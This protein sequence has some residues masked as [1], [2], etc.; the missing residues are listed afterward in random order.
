MTPTLSIIIINYNT[1][2]LVENCIQSIRQFILSIDYEIIIVDNDSSDRDILHR[3]KAPDLRIIL[4]EENLGFGKA[5]NLGY[6]YSK[7]KFILLLNPDTLLIDNS[8]ELLINIAEYNS[9]AC[10]GGIL[11]DENRQNTHS[12]GKF[13][14][15]KLFIKQYIKS[16]LPF[17]R[18]HQNLQ[19]THITKVDYITGADLL[20]PRSVIEKF[21][22]FNPAFFMYYEETDLQK[23]YN[24]AGI[25]SYI[26]PNVNIIHL[27]GGSFKKK[28]IRRLKM[29]LSGSII[30]AKLNFSLINYIIFR[31]LTLLLNIP[32]ILVYPGNWKEKLSALTLLSSIIKIK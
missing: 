16:Y 24:L 32:K 21:G 6:T 3:L 19:L 9:N 12:F 18:S 26:V 7:G 27:D 8:L 23:R 13:P 28:S 11:L 25:P 4:S 20:I 1:Y 14:T 10:Y 31:T 30:Y 15:L 5:N 2:K 17:I 22:L 29:V